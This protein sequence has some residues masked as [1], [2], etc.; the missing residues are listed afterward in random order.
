MGSYLLV[1]LLSAGATALLMPGLSVLARRWRAVDNTRDPPV[2]RV[3]GPAL[4]LGAGVGLA[5]MGLVFTPTG[6]T[7][8]A[9]SDSV[10]P[11]LAGGMAILVLG[12]LD[13]I[14]PLGAPLK[15]AAQVV[16]SLAVWAAGV[17]VELV[18]LPFGSAD[19]GSLP[20]MAVT[21]LWLIGVTNAFN[22]LDGADGVAAGSA[23]FS[24]AAVFLMSVTLGHPGIGLV[25]AGLA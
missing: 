17:R 1:F 24:S 8:L 10:G 6:N 18:S 9:S 13:D 5:L 25:A 23:F 11:V 2:P 14:R 7:L 16:V 4:A 3:G 21:V 12:V 22:L 15:L 19:L 20:G